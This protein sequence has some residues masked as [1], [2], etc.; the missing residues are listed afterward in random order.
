MVKK[1]GSVLD[2]RERAGKAPNLRWSDNAAAD[3]D[4]AQILQKEVGEHKQPR[5][6]LPESEAYFRL[7]VENA[8]DVIYRYRFQ[9]SPGFEYVSPAATAVF[10]YAPEEYYADRRLALKPIHPDDRLFLA[11]WLRSGVQ[12]MEPLVLRWTRKDGTVIWIEQK[13]RFMFDEDG[14]LMA[15][16]GIVRDISDR[17]RAEEAL[18]D[19]ESRLRLINDNMRDLVFH[20]S[21]EGRF[22]YLNPSHRAIL[23]YEP[24]E[25]LGRRASHLVHPADAGYFEDTVARVLSRQKPETAE[26]R[27]RHAA[28]SHLWLETD[29]NPLAGG[30]GGSTGGIVGTGRD[31]TA[32]KRMEESLRISEERFR[33]AFENA[34]IGMALVSSRGLWLQV[35][36]SLCRMV[37]YDRRELLGQHFNSI[38]YPG[39]LANSNKVLNKL[40]TGRIRSSQFEKRYVHKQRHLVWVLL[41]ASSV[42]DPQGNLLYFITQILD[43]TSR[44]QAEER[45]NA[46]QQQLRSLA[47]EL[48][49]TEERE[50][51]QIAGGLHDH[52]RQ[53]LALSKLLLDPLRRAPGCDAHT[54]NRTIGLIEQAIEYSRSLTIELSPPILYELGLEAAM[55]I[56]GDEFGQ[57]YGFQFQLESDQVPFTVSEDNQLLLYRAARELFTNVVK[58][59][60]ATAVKVTV[61]TGQEAVQVSVTDNGRGFDPRNT[62]YGYGLFSIR[63]RLKNQG[64]AFTIQ[65]QPDR[66]TRVV[67]TVPRVEPSQEKRR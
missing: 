46:Y 67:L 36:Q 52:V 1:V 19:S 27:Y 35:N 41:N 65:S 63:E 12:P 29:L 45:L 15:I 57:Q 56:L 10:G 25:L 2:E 49:L 50:R 32:R 13:T 34:A 28:G 40:K 59:A 11:E 22:V 30:S 48:T 44:K 4:Q 3:T 55:E 33:S 5:T 47:S 24:G 42:Y 66:G 39:D 18:M 23:G 38:T 62:D 60:Q 54:I 53:P 37:G 31:I 9:P 21:S 17:K 20:I 16:E 8:Q 14:R 26:F 58:H 6:A 51:R 61:T 43:I 7:L 64:G